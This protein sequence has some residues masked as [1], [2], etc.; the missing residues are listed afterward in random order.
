M[1]PVDL[2]ESIADRR[3]K[4]AQEA[5]LFGDLPERGNR[6]RT[7]IANACQGGWQRGWYVGVAA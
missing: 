3:I 7:S 5:G 6:Y 4:A 2:F 1:G